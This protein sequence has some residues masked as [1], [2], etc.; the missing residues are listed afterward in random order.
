MAHAVGVLIATPLWR[1]A[2]LVAVL[3]LAA[4][5]AT[6]APGARPPGSTRWWLLGA[7]G[8]LAIEALVTMPAAPAGGSDV[9]MG[10][11]LGQAEPPDPVP[12]VLGDGLVLAGPD[13]LVAAI[14]L[15]ALLAA[16]GAGP[17][18][19]ALAACAV[20]GVAVTGYAA[21]RVATLAGGTTG[22]PSAAGGA[23]AAVAV[24][25]L[26]A[27]AALALAAVAAGRGAWVAAL[28]A[29]LLALSALPRMD[30]AID[31]LLLP[32]GADRGG[33]FGAAAIPPTEALPAPV[34]ALVAGLR[35]A[36]YL[37]VVTGSGSDRAAGGGVGQLH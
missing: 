7:L 13:L 30:L 17:G 4:W 1:P 24:P 2:G 6:A 25:V 5:V 16:P 11:E 26:V 19:G 10:W 31:A 36:A 33:I 34:P 9:T 22:E 37:L 23:V 14:L 18:R 29:A 35:L 27:L 12:A 15:V 20:A 28:G 32:F 8:V 21:T 3:L